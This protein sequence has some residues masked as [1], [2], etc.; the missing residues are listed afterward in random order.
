MVSILCNSGADPTIRDGEGSTAIHIAAQFSYWPILAYLVAKGTDVDTFDTNGLTPLMWAVLRSQGPDTI[1]VLLALGADPN[2]SDRRMR[3]TPLHLAVETP[4]ATAFDLLLETTSDL[5]AENSKGVTPI[6]LATGKRDWMG[7]KIIEELEN[8]GVKRGRG[9]KRLFSTK[10]RRMA[11][12]FALSLF[13]LVSGKK[14]KLTTYFRS[15]FFRLLHHD[16][17][18]EN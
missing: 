8:R 7:E 6:S 5:Q 1:R 14:L 15:L 11:L 3:N 17:D 10:P 16:F 12:L 9:I 2:L 4:N 18:W 13:F